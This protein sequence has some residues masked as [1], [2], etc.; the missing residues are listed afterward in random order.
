MSIDI[1]VPV[2]GESIKEA[3]VAKWLKQPGEAVKADEPLV[4]LETEK[5]AVEVPAP[6]AGIMGE[7]RVKAGETVGVGQILGSIQE[8]TGGV[9]TAAARLR[10]PRA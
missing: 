9:A 10:S 4:E 2:L 3:T 7:F 1:R 6:M 5:V 8:G